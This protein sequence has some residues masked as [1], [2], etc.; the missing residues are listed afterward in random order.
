VI[1]GKKY[2]ISP[3]EVVESPSP[4]T[5][6]FLQQVD[7]K[8]PVTLSTPYQSKQ[9]VAVS[10]VSNTVSNVNNEVSSVKSK[11]E[12]FIDKYESDMEDLREQVNKHFADIEVKEGDRVKEY[13]QFQEM[14]NRRLGI[15]KDAVRTIE[16]E[17][18]GDTSS[19]NS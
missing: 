15:L 13:I 10:E 11:L 4:L 2:M 1:Q 14:V 6:I 19:K 8:I 16:E 5:Y 3:G 17:V 7:E 18:Y 12:Q 9:V